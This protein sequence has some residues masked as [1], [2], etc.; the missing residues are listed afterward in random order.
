RF[1]Y[2]F[3][4]GRTPVGTQSSNSLRHRK[5]SEVAR[6]KLV[7]QWEFC[8]LDGRTH[9]HVPKPGRPHETLQFDGVMKR[10]RCSRH[11]ASLGTYVLHQRSDEGR[12]VGRVLDGAPH[13]EG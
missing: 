10:M 11:R 6:D 4:K 7:W 1:G 5:R 9:T 3:D 2:V 13:R 12:R 8:G